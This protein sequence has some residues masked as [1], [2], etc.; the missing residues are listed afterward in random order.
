MSLIYRGSR[1]GFDSGDFLMRC[2]GKVPTICFVRSQNYNKI[3]GGFTNVRWMSYTWEKD[4]TAFIF[5]LTHGEKF[6]V[7]Q[8]A[9][10]VARFICLCSWWDDLTISSNG[11]VKRGYSKFPENYE[12]GKF[13]EQSAE[14]RKYLAGAEDFS[15]SELE[16][17]QISYV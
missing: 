5:S 9:I 2:E 17:Y 12:C 1:D 8:D 14:S 16:F 3:F 7:K 10:A 13:K 6:K 15:I 4:P 11:G